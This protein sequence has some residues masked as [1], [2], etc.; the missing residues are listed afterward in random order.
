M[1]WRERSFETTRDGVDLDF[2]IRQYG[3][4][5]MQQRLVGKSLPVWERENFDSLAAGAR[6]LG[7]DMAAAMSE[8]TRTRV[9]DT[10][11]Y[12]TRDASALRLV[13]IMA[14]RVAGD[15]MIERTIAQLKR[16]CD[17]IDEVKFGSAS[18]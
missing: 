8:P 12:E 11:E 6:L 17:G 14:G 10:L 18:A 16:V 4:P 7:N 1:A 3:S 5:V 15:A 9:R 13:Q 2:I